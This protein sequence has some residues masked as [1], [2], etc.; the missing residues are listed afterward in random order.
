MSGFATRFFGHAVIALSMLS[1]LLLTGCGAGSSTSSQLQAIAQ[2]D[3]SSPVNTADSP[4]AFVY[5]SSSPSG[6]KI[7]INAYKVHSDGKL[8]LVPGSPFPTHMAYSASMASSGKHLFFTDEVNILSYS[9]AK[10]GSL[11]SSGSIDAQGLNQAN[12][13]GPA[14]LF[15]DRT[16]ANLYDWDIYSDCANNAYQFF[17]AEASGQLSY[18]G[19]TSA[20]SPIFYVPL[21]FTGNNEYAYGASCYHWSQEIFGFRRTSDGTLTDLN[22]APAMPTSRTGQMYCPFLAAADAANHVAVHMQVLNSSSL[23]PAGPSQLATYTADGSGNL[24]TTS[25]YSNMPAVAVSTVTDIAMSPSG[26]LLAIAGTGGL[27]VF[28]F[29]GAHPITTYSGLLTTDE[30]DQVAWDNAD[31]LYAISRTAG[32]L[33][34]FTITPT[35]HTPAARSPYAITKPWNIAVVTR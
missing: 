12:C 16:G 13:G 18:V 9:I 26:K 3:P 33:F 6:N 8:S 24:S 31:H 23:Q 10:D 4:A 7:E 29:N 32:K 21:S 17:D 1:A 11:Q 5:V 30:V 19:V 15:L 14:A 20:S 28:H 2:E 22:L 27:Q 35:S 34:V 25:T